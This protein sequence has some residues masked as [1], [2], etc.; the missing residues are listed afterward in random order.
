[1]GRDGEGRG[2]GGWQKLGQQRGDRGVEFNSA[3]ANLE[4]IQVFVGPHGSSAG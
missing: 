4:S 2:G 1:M 3:E